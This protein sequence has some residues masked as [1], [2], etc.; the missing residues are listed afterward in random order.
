MPQNDDTQTTE[1]WP[2]DRATRLN[3]LA[4]IGRDHGSFKRL[5]AHHSA[6]FVEESETLVVSFDSMV[7]LQ[8]PKPERLPLGFAMVESAEVSLLSILSTEDSWFRDP[9]LYQHFDDLVDDGFFD[10]FERILF[11]GLGP[12]C[13][14]GAATYSV[15]APGAQVLVTNPVA[16]LSR[17]AAPFERRFKS[18]WRQDFSSR[19]G[20]APFMTDAAAAVTLIYDPMEAMGASQAALFDGPNVTRLKLRYGG[21]DIGGL[22][23]E[24]GGLWRLASEA[25]TD[26]ITPATL[27]KVARMARRNSPSYVERLSSAADQSGHPKLALAAARYGKDLAGDGRFNEMI[28]LLADRDE[29][30]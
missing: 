6:L 16:S 18:A 9:A 30:A 11:V 14:Y 25:L 22:L 12:R 19:Y 23:Q 5:S 17:D 3:R 28:G 29:Q 8:E 21:A 26:G 10:G 27:S 2:L 15:A 4:E 20:Y 1:T 13:G 7:R 24:H